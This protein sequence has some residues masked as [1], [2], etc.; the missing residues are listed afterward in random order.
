M[1]G[2]TARSRWGASSGSCSD[3]WGSPQKPTDPPVAGRTM[4]GMSRRSASPRL[5]GR[6]QELADLL[7]AVA[8][9]DRERP[10]ILV[11]GEVEIGKTRL[12][13]ELVEQARGSI[14]DP[15]SAAAF[16]RGSCLRLAEGELPFA[17]V[18]EILDGLREQ[19]GSGSIRGAAN[20]SPGHGPR[21]PAGTCAT[22]TLQVHRDPRRHS[23]SLRVS[24]VSRSSSMTCT[25][26][27]QST[28][29]LV[30]FLARRLRGGPVVLL[31]AFRSDQ[32]HRRHPLRPAVVAEL[33][34]GY[35]RGASRSG[36]A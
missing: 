34:R 24:A 32:L 19:I 31:A 4:T 3:R 16:A 28:L 35:V 8:A 29:D 22:R 23:L 9:D 30:L 33:S 7:A 21:R 20:A 2:P 25:W 12:L 18:L 17:P 10:V 27:D 13:S 6:E 11:A 1:L 5:V 26:A 36:A 14:A 15:S